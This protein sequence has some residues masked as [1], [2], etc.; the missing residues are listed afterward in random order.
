MQRVKILLLEPGVDGQEGQPRTLPGM[1]HQHRPK[2]EAVL[3]GTCPPASRPEAHTLMSARHAAGVTLGLRHHV[4]NSPGPKELISR[5]APTSTWEL[6]AL[7]PLPFLVCPDPSSL[8]CWP[9]PCS[10]SLGT[11]HPLTPSRH[12]PPQLP[13]F[14]STVL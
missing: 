5:K 14:A 2:Y 8:S 4:Q 9:P 1:S 10:G 13:A 7:G 3:T 12:R 11:S 6:D